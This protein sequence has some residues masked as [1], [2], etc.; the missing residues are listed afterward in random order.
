M[1]KL[2][3]EEGISVVV[4]SH[5]LSEMELMC[6]RVAILQHGKLIDVRTIGDLLPASDDELTVS[7][8]VDQPSR[9][10]EVI[11]DKMPSVRRS[12]TPRGFT[13]VLDKQQIPRI[14]T[15]LVGTGVRVFA[16]QYEAKTLEDTFLE[17]TR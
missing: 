15:M 17:M 2:A 10:L 12:L 5:L 6:D 9:A 1:R 11:N 4:S 7:F 14:I 16:I 8:E 3:R 13:A